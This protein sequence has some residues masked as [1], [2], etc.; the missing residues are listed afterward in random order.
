[1][2][3]PKLLYVYLHT[4]Y[5]MRINKILLFDHRIK[6]KIQKIL[7]K[8]NFVIKNDVNYQYMTWVF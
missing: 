5:C 4:I 2:I 1:M 3:S 8:L 6:K 7:H